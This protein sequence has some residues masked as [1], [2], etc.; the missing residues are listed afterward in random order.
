M[1]SSLP[2]LAP[3]ARSLT[4]DCQRI[5]EEQRV[6]SK[7]AERER[8][9]ELKQRESLRRQVVQMVIDEMAQQERP[10]EIAIQLEQQKKSLAAIGA[11]HADDRYALQRS[12]LYRRFYEPT[13]EERE[14]REDNWHRRRSEHRLQRDARLA[15]IQ[16][17]VCAL[18]RGSAPLLYP[19]VAFS[20]AFTVVLSPSLSHTH[21]FPPRTFR[22]RPFRAQALEE[23]RSHSLAAASQRRL[24]EAKG[25][26]GE[27]LAKIA[28]S[29]SAP[30]LRS[31]PPT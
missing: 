24:L 20:H 12:S 8:R 29:A 18:S 13:R 27:R 17:C 10:R 3:Y 26:Y 4:A 9:R 11:A 30:S 14:Q 15:Q 28:S 2:R 31:L 5:Q 19:R 21:T 25:R 1:S 16:V 22:H 23:A 6:R 7:I